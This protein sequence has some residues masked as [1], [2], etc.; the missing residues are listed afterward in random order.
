M[1]SSEIFETDKEFL[2]SAIDGVLTEKATKIEQEKFKIES[3]K[4]KIEFEKIKLEQ[5]PYAFT[6]VVKMMYRMILIHESQQPL[7]GI[8]WKEI[9]EDP[10]K[11]FEM[12]TVT[13]GTVSA[14]FLVTRTLLKLS[15]EEKKNFPSAAPVLRENFYVDD[16]LCGAASLMEALKNQLSNIL[17]KGIM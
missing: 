13:Y 6:A 8:L 16:V 14:P 4:D 5:H 11:N 7:L 2:Q 12:K 3:E 17:K 10:V 15:R 9:P 1:E